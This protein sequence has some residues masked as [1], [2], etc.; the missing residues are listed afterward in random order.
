LVGSLQHSLGKLIEEHA[1]PADVEQRERRA[2]D[3]P[4]NPQ[5][6]RPLEAA[7]LLDRRELA[8]RHVGFGILRPD[9]QRLAAALRRFRIKEAEADTIVLRVYNVR[10]PVACILREQLLEPGRLGNCGQ[11]P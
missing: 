5:I 8:R 6:V 2:L 7:A 1:L 10:R 4:Q 11:R 9:F 3:R